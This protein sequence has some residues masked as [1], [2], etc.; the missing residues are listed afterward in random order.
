M[1]TRVYSFA[2][3]NDVDE[4]IPD[5]AYYGS[6]KYIVII[7]Y[8]ASFGLYDGVRTYFKM[9]NRGIVANLDNLKKMI[10]G[11]GDLDVCYVCTPETMSLIRGLADGYVVDSIK[12]NIDIN[13]Y[14]TGKR[15][16][17]KIDNASKR[18]IVKILGYSGDYKKTY[19]LDEAQFAISFKMFEKSGFTIPRLV[20]VKWED[21]KIQEATNQ[22]YQLIFETGEG[23]INAEEFAK[24]QQRG[25]WEEL[26][27]PKNTDKYNYDYYTELYDRFV[28]YYKR[29]SLEVSRDEGR[30]T[31]KILDS[32]CAK[33]ERVDEAQNKIVFDKSK[34]KPINEFDIQMA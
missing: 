34:V 29:K 11:D 21:R 18:Q 31:R 16:R 24:L 3:A 28:G 5:G 30:N 14:R 1:H 7:H 33:L 22:V 26:D 17:V 8:D 4:D 6:S 15:K 2:F 19:L 25:K 12:G 32:M 20:S 23:I 9:F 13:G 10:K 27:W